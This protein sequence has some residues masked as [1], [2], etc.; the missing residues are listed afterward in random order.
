MLSCKE[1]R[2]NIVAYIDDEL[3]ENERRLFEEHVLGCKECSRELDEMKQ[4]IGLC[5]DMPLLEL[6]PDFK[7]NL[8]E[9][10]TAVADEQ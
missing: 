2:E 9:K 1:I 3:N 6:P 5:T 10:L 7:E 8:H 4:V